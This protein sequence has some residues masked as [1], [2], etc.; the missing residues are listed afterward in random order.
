[1]KHL[2][3]SVAI[4]AGTAAHADSTTAK[5]T[6]HYTYVS[7]SIPATKTECYDVEVPIY[8]RTQSGNAAEGALLGMIIGGISGKAIT[9]KDNGAAAGA[10]IGGI[11]GAD[12]AQQG[13]KTITGYRIEKKCEEITYYVEQKERVYD[14]STISF[15]VGGE[16]YTLRFVK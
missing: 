13:R 4:L 15:K 14:Y 16:R 10:V 11:I 3:I 1:M 9:G 6:D 5:I 2:L 7:K 8:G 12:K